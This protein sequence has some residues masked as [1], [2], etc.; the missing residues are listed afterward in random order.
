MADKNLYERLGLTRDASPE[1]IRRAYRD[2]ARRLHPDANVNPGDTELF[3]GVQEAF[4]RLSDQQTRTSYDEGLPPEEKIQPPLVVSAIYSRS[5]LARIIEPQLIYVLLGLDIKPEIEANIRPNLNIC[6]VLD[7]STSMQGLR[8]DTVKATAIELIRQ[9]HPQDI[10][11][12]VK[13]SD[14]AEVLIPAGA[15]VDKH[16]AEAKI[17]LLQ[18]GGGTE[19]FQGLEKGFTEVRNYRSP[20]RINHV[21][22]ITDGRT[23]G[24]EDQCVRLAEQATA[25]GVAFSALG[26]GSQWNDAFLDRLTSL[27]GGNS[28]FVS[29]PEDLRRFILDKIS[30]LGRSFA[31]HVTYHFQTSENIELTYAFR[32]QPDSSPLTTQNPLVLGSVP[33][34]ASHNMLLE[35]TVKDLP[36]EVNRVNLATGRLTYEIP[37]NTDNPM[38]I[39]RLDLSRPVKSDF[40][41]EPPPPQLV[42]AIS[43]L[44]LYRMQERAREDMARGNPREAGRRLQNLATHLLAHGERDL[45]RSVLS[46]VAHIQQNQQFSE[47]GEKRIK[48]GTRS[49]MLPDKKDRKV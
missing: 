41:V 35:F 18:A 9:L 37:G 30:R 42:Q 23:Y 43:K 40:D 27:T 32:L 15:W 48:Y 6:L 39:E 29:K 21:I 7:C 22:L 5:A 46:E 14:K 36:P 3:M 24:D 11:S 12:L 45:A 44:S 26:I 47:E 10:L 33:R 16:A 38:F 1:E 20:N 31:E 19:I 28:R 49:L 17:Q 34:D 13:F 4:D 25:M 8:M 2:L